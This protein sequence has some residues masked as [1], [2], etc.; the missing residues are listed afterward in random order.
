MSDDAIDAFDPLLPEFV[1]QHDFRERFFHALELV[2][3]TLD[4]ETMTPEH[5]LTKIGIIAR[6]ALDHESI[7]VW[8]DA[9]RPM[10]WLDD[11]L[12][13]QAREITEFVLKSLDS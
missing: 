9:N 4:D 2:V 10:P 13:D 1:L 11:K 5:R 12:G 8:M 7:K 6:E 3:E